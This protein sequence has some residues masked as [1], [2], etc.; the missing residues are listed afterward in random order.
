MC[1]QH[2]ELVTTNG[3]LPWSQS[4]DLN[5]VLNCQCRNC[6]NTWSK[7]TKVV[8]FGIDA[9][10][11]F[12]VAVAINP[13]H[14]RLLLSAHL[15]RCQNGGTVTAGFDVIVPNSARRSVAVLQ[16]GA[17]APLLLQP[18]HSVTFRSSLD[19]LQL[20]RDLTKSRANDRGGRKCH[21]GNVFKLS[22]HGEC[23]VHKLT[24]LS[25][26]LSVDFSLFVSSLCCIHFLL[27]QALVEKKRHI[28]ES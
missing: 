4:T 5:L 6:R 8:F 7:I 13:D 22:P 16:A 9:F 10:V 20:C 3:F 18:H 28:S 15:H 23:P 24:P 19:A 11:L 21:L 17:T 14:K 26:S 25:L 1:L 2:L 27:T 12:P